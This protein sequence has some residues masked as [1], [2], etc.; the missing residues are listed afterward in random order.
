MARQPTH[1]VPRERHEPDHPHVSR[2][3]R[4]R[5]M[6]LALV[7]AR[8]EG[9]APPTADAY[10]RALAQWRQ[11]PGAIATSATDLGNV[12]FPSTTDDRSAL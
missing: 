3:G 7:A 6:Q 4:D 12:S 8:W 2:E 1:D 11:L 10:A 5:A 9:S